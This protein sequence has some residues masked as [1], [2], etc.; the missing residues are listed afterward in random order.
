MSLLR[1]GNS[2]YLTLGSSGG[3]SL[4]AVN[5]LSSGNR[6]GQITFAGADGTDIN[7]H[8]ASIAAYVN[9]SVSSNNVP[10]A[11][12]FQFGSSE[13]EKLRI[14]SDGLSVANST[15]TSAL[16]INNIR[17]SASAPSFNE[18]NADGF[19]VDVYNTG[20]PYPRYVSLAARGYAST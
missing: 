13:S 1:H 15:N 8:A 20:N 10:A 9:G 14:S 19:L 16:C 6:I 17:G 11:I 5:A 12:T 3:S 18:A 7:T 4:G 2:P